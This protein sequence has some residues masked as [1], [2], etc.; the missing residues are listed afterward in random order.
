[1]KEKLEQASGNVFIAVEAIYSMDGDQAPLKELVDMCR[2][3]D[4]AL[5][6]DE[7]HSCGVYGEQG[8]GLVAEYGLERDVFARVVTFGKAYGCH[9]AAVLG[10]KLLRDYLINFSR[11][12]IYTTALPIQS[13]LTIQKAHHF[14]LEHLDRKDELRT[15]IGRVRSLQD[16]LNL[17]M[18]TSESAI[19]CI[20]VPGNEEV[21]KIANIAQT[22]GFDV[23]PI[24]SPTVEKGKERLRIC[25]HSYNTKEQVEDLLKLIANQL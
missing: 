23:R 9:G 14:L 15:L 4:A 22:K 20:L 25:L 6:V 8:E 2:E 11:S 17:P 1:L 18:I 7:A 21:K 5:I 10:N 12:F 13:V 19:Q 3:K 16:E 24:L